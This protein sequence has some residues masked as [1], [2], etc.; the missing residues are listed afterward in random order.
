MAAEIT[1]KI[2]KVCVRRG[3][4]SIA[5]IGLFAIGS[6]AMAVPARANYIQNATFT[7]TTG[8][9]G[10]AGGGLNTVSDYTSGGSLTN[11]TI[12]DVSGSSGLALL[13]VQGN[14][15]STTTAGDGVTLTGRFGNFSIFDPGNIAGTTPHGGAIPNTSPGGGNFIAADGASGYNVAIYQT[16]TNLSPGTVYSVSF[17]YAAAQ[18]YNFSGNTTEGWQVSLENSAQLTQ[19]AANGT[20]IQDTPTQANIPGVGT[21]GLANGSF[22]AWAQATFTFTAA[23]STQVL[24][25]LSMGTPSGQPP[26]DLLSDVVMNPT[27]EPASFAISGIGMAA[28]IAFVWRRRS[29]AIECKASSQN[30]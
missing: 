9:F 24:T 22:Q 30:Q 28:L 27:P 16:L 14:Q 1:E 5:L 26:M 12:S 29:R 13:Y 8:T 3:L 6:L 25:F 2:N 7:S 18:Q 10:A 19:V 23:S 21:P 4:E 11:W 20:T 17:W 15:G